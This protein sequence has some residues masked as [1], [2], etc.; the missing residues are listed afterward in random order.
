MEEEIVTDLSNDIDSEKDFE[1]KIIFRV[2]KAQEKE[3][4]DS[5]DDDE[6]SEDEESVSDD[7]SDEL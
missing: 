4:E 6:D 3:S 7:D 5:I 2:G 1:M